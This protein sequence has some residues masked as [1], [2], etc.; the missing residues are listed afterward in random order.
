MKIPSLLLKCGSLLLITTLI[1][2]KETL[3][4]EED[5]EFDQE[6]KIKTVEEI[7]SKNLVEITT[8]NVIEE[9]TDSEPIFQPKNINDNDNNE[10]DEEEEESR[11]EKGETY[12]NDTNNKSSNKKK[13]DNDDENAEGDE[14]DGDGDEEGEESSAPTCDVEFF[15]EK[16]IPEDYYPHEPTSSSSEDNPSAANESAGP[17]SPSVVV[18]HLNET[19]ERIN[20][21][22]HFTT[23]LSANLTPFLRQLASHLSDL[24]YEAKL[25]YQCMGAFMHLFTALGDQKSWAI[26][27]KF[28]IVL[29]V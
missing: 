12:K 15:L 24:L 21:M 8:I 13:S 17:K 2:A 28:K 26:G 19:I 3:S 22:H 10:D 4:S 20:R 9:T 25:P 29:K 1:S 14:S 11:N 5:A 27:C 16:L 6:E 18:H 23:R 7:Y